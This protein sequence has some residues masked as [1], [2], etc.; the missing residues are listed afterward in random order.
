MSSNKKRLDI[1]TIL[2]WSCIALFAVCVHAFQYRGV[3]GEADLYRVLN[4]LLDGA[5]SGESWSPIFTMV[6]TSVLLH[7]WRSLRFI[8]G[9]SPS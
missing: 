9:S 6:E 5:N 2:A 8:V 7:L 3:L 4:G 1:D